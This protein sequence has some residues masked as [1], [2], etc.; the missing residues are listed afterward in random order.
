M[1]ETIKRAIISLL[2]LGLSYLA[3]YNLFFY[4][5]FIIT[6]SIVSVI[7]LSK[8]KS[9]YSKLM[10]LTQVYLFIKLFINLQ[11]FHL[12]MGIII[13][14]SVSDVIQYVFGK[15]FGTEPL[16]DF[17]SKTMEG[18][19]SGIFITYYIFNYNFDF[20][21]FFV[22]YNML[23][24]IGGMISSIMKRKQNIKHWS[25]LLGPHGGINDRLDSVV[26]PLIVFFSDN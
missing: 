9:I 23:G 20:P 16:F 11:Y 10:L 12:V 15:L 4:I 1:I 6:I 13:Y 21:S 24:M 25:N 3:Y 2:L 22:F 8:N 14:N 19:V 5:F 26:L 7:E 18:Y 17:T